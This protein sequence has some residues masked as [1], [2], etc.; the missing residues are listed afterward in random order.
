M[1]PRPK[2]S[3]GLDPVYVLRIGVM[4]ANRIGPFIKFTFNCLI[5]KI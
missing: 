3:E 1:W 4:D 5:F 2:F